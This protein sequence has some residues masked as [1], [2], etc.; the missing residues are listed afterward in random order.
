MGSMLV[1]LQHFVKDSFKDESETNLKRMDFGE[2]K[3]MVERGDFIFI[4][5]VLNGSRT[6]PMANR[7]QKV[8][9]N[10]DDKYGIELIGW[11][12]DL[13]KVRGVKDEAS[14][15]FERVGFL[16]RFVEKKNGRN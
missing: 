11:D 8:L 13:E 15:L 12:G 6:G 1:A 7:L 5:A 3:V 4:A 10:I 16:D 9:Q 2:K 14:P